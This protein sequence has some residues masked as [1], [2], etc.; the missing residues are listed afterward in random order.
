[1]SNANE[2]DSL[3]KQQAEVEEKEE[4]DMLFNFFDFDDLVGTTSQQNTNHE[5]KK[6]KKE[7]NGEEEEF[8][9]IALFEDIDEDE[10]STN[11]A[12]DYQTLDGGASAAPPSTLQQ[13]SKSFRSESSAHLLVY[14]FF[15]AAL[16]G[17][18]HPLI[19]SFFLTNIIHRNNSNNENNN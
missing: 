8:D 5:S 19:F 6:E 18:S 4:E 15:E 17:A 7:E 16:I 3:S 11:K 2:P 12:A 9:M 10:A 14:P 13:A 1:M